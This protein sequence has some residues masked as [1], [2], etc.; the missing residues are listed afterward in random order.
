[1]CGP[2][3]L[4]PV[5]RLCGGGGGAE[6]PFWGGRSPGNG[7]HTDGKSL[8]HEYLNHEKERV[9]GTGDWIWLL[10]CMGGEYHQPTDDGDHHQPVRFGSTHLLRSRQ[11][12]QDVYGE[13][14]GLRQPHHYLCHRQR[15]LE[16][17]RSC[18]GIGGTPL[19]TWCFCQDINRSQK[20]P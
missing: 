8:G 19:I 6:H 20:M 1:M 12:Q 5:H 11:Q 14:C 17:D 18:P 16:R 9:L 10:S 2:C 7:N 13:W 15:S 4:F 3:G